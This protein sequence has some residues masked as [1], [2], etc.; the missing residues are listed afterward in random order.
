MDLCSKWALIWLV[1]KVFWNIFT[2]A[3]IVTGHDTQVIFVLI[4]IRLTQLSLPGHHTGKCIPAMDDK[5]TTKFGLS[6]EAHKDILCVPS[7]TFK[8]VH[9]GCEVRF[10]YTN[11]HEALCL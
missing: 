4:E 9:W 2:L 7:F 1:A 11:Y 3:A 6:K 10:K 5:K 8:S